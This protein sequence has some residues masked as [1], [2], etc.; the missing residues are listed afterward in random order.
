M[1]NIYAIYVWETQNKNNIKEGNT[2]IVIFG[3]GQRKE[4]TKLVN[5][6]E[7]KILYDSGPRWNNAHDMGDRTPNLI[8]VVFERISKNGEN[9]SV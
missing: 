7:I 3:Q 1:S 9:S 2:Y 4:Y 5:D 6:P 8:C